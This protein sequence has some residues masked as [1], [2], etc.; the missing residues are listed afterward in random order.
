VRDSF[1]IGSSGSIFCSAQSDSTDK[2]LASMFDAGY[3]ITCRDAALPVGRMYKLRDAA[4][5]ARLAAARAD[6]VA[7][8]EPQAGTV[9]GLGAVQVIEC[10]LKDADVGYR[11]YQLRKGK[12]F[13]SAEGLAGYDS[14][15]QLGLRSLIADQPVKGEI[16]IATT[17]LGDP[18]AFAR[19]QAGT[20]DPGKALAEAYRRNNAGSYA[21]AAEFFAA[22]STSGEAPVSRAEGLANEALQKSNLGRFAEADA[23]FARAA[24]QVGSDP[25]VARRLRNYRAIHDLNQGD[26]KAALAELDK[27]LPKAVVE[28]EQ[29]QGVGSLAIDAVTS[30]RLNADSKVGKQLSA[31]SDELLPAE[32]AEILDGQALQLRGTSLRVTG[33]LAGASDALRRA[34]AKLEAVRGGKVASIL[35]MRAQILGDLA[36]IAEDGGNAAEADRL[37]R[38]GVALLESNYPGSA[39]LLNAK[40]RLAG[41]LARNGQLATAEAMFRDIVHSQSDASN[42]PPSFAQVLR[43][44]VDLLLKKGDDP[45]AMAEIFAAT[46]LMIRPG[47]AQTQAVLARELTGGTDEASRLFRQSVT[48]TRQIERSRIELARIEDNPKPTPEEAVRARALRASLGQTEKEQIATQ[49]ALAG[50]PRYRAVSSEVISLADLQKILKPGEAYYRMTIVGDHIYAMLVTPASARAV[51]LQTTSKQLAEQ[52]DA[53]RDT[54]STIENGQRVTYAFDVSLSHQLYGELFAPFDSELASVKHLVFEPDGAMLRLPPNLLVTDQASVD[55]YTKRAAAGGDAEFDF[56]GISWFGRDRD[57]STAVSPRSFAQLRSA[58]PSAGQKEYLGLG[59]NTPPAANAQTIPAA[60]DRDCILPLA[61]WAH[62]IS[63]KELQVA[64]GILQ[65]IDPQGVKIITRD[66]FTDTGLEA[67]NDLGDYRIV[68]FATHGVV[69]SRAPKCAAQ[70]ALLTSFGG[71]GSDGLLTFRE[72]FDLHLDADLVILSA[73]DTAG[74]AS[75]A[76]TQQAGLSTGGDVALDGLVR[77]FVGAGG[78]LVLASHWPVPDDFNAT[79]RLITGLFSA[80]PGTPTVTALRLSQRQLMDDPNTSH[81]FYWSAFASVGDGEIPVIRAKQV[82]AQA[83]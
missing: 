23:L 78:R 18:S 22:V 17:G 83:H 80:P 35:W 8:S 50:F 12:L 69:T 51:K 33:N 27:P 43:P 14:A 68:H 58:P 1:R 46:Q 30:K 54:I 75:A 77:A 37:Y 26:P 9:P 6:K 20:L 31:E 55:M 15:V 25:I 41:Y 59:E 10:K 21:E 44:Y 13:Y 64:G 16:S 57:I 52:V 47:L 70:P 40:A 39:A 42:L 53:L 74:K 73:C 81:P 61:S 62:P 45:A 38:Q 3:S 28:Q 5:P 71:E 29:A 24:E 60:A 66:E 19:V 63:A 49:S 32:K 2:A 76:A 82:I 11:V 34:E 56:R 4:A 36:A 79:Q 7:C 67:R 72:I 48:L 65:V